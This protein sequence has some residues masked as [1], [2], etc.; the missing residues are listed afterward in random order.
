MTSTDTLV[1]QQ[2]CN[3]SEVGRLE[4]ILSGRAPSLDQVSAY[5]GDRP[6]TEVE[7][8]F[9]DEVRQQ[10]GEQF[11]SDLLYAVTHQVF[12]PASACELWGAILRHKYELSEVLQR[13]I[14]ITV[15][16]LDYLGNLR[17]EL[18][19]AT[20]IAEARMTDMVRMTQRDGLTNLYNHASFFQKLEQELRCYERCQRIVTIMMIDVDNFKKINDRFGH[21][22]GDEVLVALAALIERAVRT[23]DICCRYGGEEFAVILPA[24]GALEAGLLAERLLALL[25]QAKPGGHNLTVSIGVAACGESMGT[26]HAFVVKADAALYAAKKEGKNRIVISSS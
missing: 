19:S 9:F 21:P 12:A 25:A 4:Q 7:R 3:V 1:T 22:A 11:F 8:G 18:R 2:F 14:R 6:L 23:T 15:A 17:G 13:N 5:A 26:T 20:V 24:T 10:R 16:A